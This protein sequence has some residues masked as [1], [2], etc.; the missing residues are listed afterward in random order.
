MKLL[1]IL[2]L[3]ALAITAEIDGTKVKECVDELDDFSDACDISS[4]DCNDDLDALYENEAATD[5]E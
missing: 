2:I 5:E 4:V 1:I 3:I